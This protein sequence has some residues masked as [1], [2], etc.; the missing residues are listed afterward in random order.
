MTFTFDEF[1]QTATKLWADGDLDLSGVTPDRFDEKAVTANY[2]L[3]S[4]HKVHD[5]TVATTALQTEVTGTRARPL[6][7][8]DISSFAAS[9]GSATAFAMCFE[10]AVR[11]IGVPPANAGVVA[12]AM[13]MASHC[14][15]ARHTYCVSDSAELMRVASFHGIDAEPLGSAKT[16]VGVHNH[17]KHQYIVA[18]TSRFCSR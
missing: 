7:A 14:G 1:G 15:Y 6:R 9:S 17:G 16:G 13:T 10:M 4:I 3:P 18:S 2:A 8:A 5:A 12:L 11:V